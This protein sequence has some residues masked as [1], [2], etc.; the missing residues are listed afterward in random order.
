VKNGKLS[1][2]RNIVK[3]ILRDYYDVIVLNEVFEMACVVNCDEA[4]DNV[5]PY[6]SIVRGRTVKQWNMV[7]RDT[8]QMAIENGQDLR[9][10]AWCFG[11]HA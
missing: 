5:Y 4:L 6:H 7:G 9:G 3:E 10:E 1:E 8:Q 2:F 11:L